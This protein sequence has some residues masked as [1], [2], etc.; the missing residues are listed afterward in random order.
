MTC[1]EP[2]SPYPAFDILL[3]FG[4]RLKYDGHGLYLTPGVPPSDGTYGDVV[5]KDGALLTAKA[6]PLPVYTPAP[7]VPSAEPCGDQG[8][9]G[10]SGSGS[11]APSLSSDAGNLLTYDASGYLLAKVYV[12]GAVSGTGTASNPLS[13]ATGSGGGGTVALRSDTPTILK[14][15]GAGTASQPW[16]LSH[17]APTNNVSGSHGGLTLD[18]F[19]H[20]TGFVDTGDSAAGIMIIQAVPGTVDVTVERGAA[21]IGLP[22]KHS[23]QFIVNTDDWALTVDIYGR[24]VSAAPRDNFVSCAWSRVFKGSRTSFAMSLV[25]THAGKIRGTYRGD[26][27]ITASTDQG[28]TALPSTVTVTVADMSVEAFARLDGTRVTGLE[29]VTSEVFAPG[30]YQIAVTLPAAIT[31]PGILDVTL[32][33]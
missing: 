10:G 33:L 25:T 7:C 29:F 27:G 22:F 1:T 31:A 16:R 17:V 8:S 6:A 4:V 14:L 5:V 3:P 24:I 13:A 12:T 11:G 21:V 28:L 9:G 20:V 18:A 15:E 19:G 32:C 2:Q 30:T 23:G 26:L